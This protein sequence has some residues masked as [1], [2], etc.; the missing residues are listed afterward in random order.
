V[1][2]ARVASFGGHSL[3]STHTGCEPMKLRYF[4]IKGLQVST[5]AKND[6]K[7]GD[8]MYF[9]DLSNIITR[10][11]FDHDAPGKANGVPVLHVVGSACHGIA[12]T[13]P[14]C[15]PFLNV[16]GDRKVEA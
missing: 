14:C 1:L 12:L 11:R 4:L 2:F 8:E 13:P 7:V 9:W 15:P 5:R 16:L 10:G 3:Q 6:P